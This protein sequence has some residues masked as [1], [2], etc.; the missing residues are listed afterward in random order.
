MPEGRKGLRKLF[1]KIAASTALSGMLLTGAA[2]SAG[3]AEVPHQAVQNSGPPATQTVLPTPAVLPPPAANAATTQQ[4]ATADTGCPAF[5][6]FHR[7]D[8]PMQRMT[9]NRTPD[10]ALQASQRNLRVLGIEGGSDGLPGNDVHAAVN[11]YLLFYGPLYGTKLDH[12]ALTENDAAQLKTYADKAASDAK[13]PL[14]SKL[15]PLS[16]AKAAALRLASLRSGADY[17]ALAAAARNGGQLAGVSG[18]GAKAGDLFKF[19]NATWLYLVK[20]F[21]GKYGLDVYAG[22]ITL[23]TAD[24]K[25]AAAMDNPFLHRQLLDLKA[26]PRLSAL[27]GGEY[28]MHK[29]AMPALAHP[30]LP[31][32]D[33]A[34]QA[35]QKD[36]A[37]IG[38]DIGAAADGRKGE[39]TA[40]AIGEY[41]VLYGDGVATG[42]LSAGE[43]AKLHGFALKAAADAKTYKVP[44]VA[45]GAI[46]MAS[47]KSGG[48][49]PY[50][51]ELASAESSF[52]HTVRAQGTSATGLYQFIESTWSDMLRRYGD[53]YGLGDYASQVTTYKDSLGR[54]QA[55]IENPLL[56]A[57]AMELRKNPQLAAL[58]SADF[59]RENMAKEACYVP[60][61][62]ARTDLYLA[63]FLGPSDAVYFLGQMRA[64]AVQSAVTTFPEEASYNVNIF[65]ETSHGKIQ[66]ERSLTEVYN[67]LDHKFN[68]GLYDDGTLLVIAPV[69]NAQTKKP[70]PPSGAS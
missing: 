1:N 8:A 52:V 30:A 5:P 64:N 36:L 31:G 59:Q 69:P 48:D 40:I 7:P 37:A 49:F 9:R 67:V 60:G 11:E 19:D 39:I 38:F 41:Q 46:R 3:G 18:K 10:A 29:D 14:F 16:T 53:K 25:T 34:T 28:L 62:L 15:A 26:N 13:P 33:A 66:R 45:V 32:F 12:N 22:H 65:Y 58:I 6:E 57:G 43:A 24:G 42:T 63:H 27:L 56:R 35:Q 55:R 51:M 2:T 23:T 44:E 50:L 54:D 70:P 61:Q 20:T 47:D 17:T 68:R 4:A 21:G